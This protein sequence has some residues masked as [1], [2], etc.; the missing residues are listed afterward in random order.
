MAGVRLIPLLACL[1]LNVK[2]SP[3][4]HVLELHT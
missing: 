4:H 2:N 3:S 1:S